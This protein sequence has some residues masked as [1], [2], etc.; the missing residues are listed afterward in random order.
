MRLIKVELG[1]A[2]DGGRKVKD[3]NDACGAASVFLAMDYAHADQPVQDTLGLAAIALPDGLIALHRVE[4]RCHAREVVVDTACFAV[5]R[6]MRTPCSNK[7]L[8]SL[9]SSDFRMSS[10]Q[11]RMTSKLFPVSDIAP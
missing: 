3:W 1:C 5:G 9:S 4:C 8:C 6:Q 2:L 10:G 11:S 7:L